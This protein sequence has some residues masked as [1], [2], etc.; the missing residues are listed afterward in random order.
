MQVLWEKLSRARDTEFRRRATAQGMLKAGMTFKGRHEVGWGGNERYCSPDKD[1]KCTCW[2]Q[3]VQLTK[4]QRWRGLEC[5]GN[6]EEAGYS[7]GSQESSN[8]RH[9]QSALTGSP[10]IKWS[11][12]DHFKGLEF[13]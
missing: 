4:G 6:G 10:P 8:K 12:L 11:A 5:S 13:Y 7:R 9:T 1:R 2:P 3:Q